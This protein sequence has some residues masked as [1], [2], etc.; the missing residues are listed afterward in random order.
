MHKSKV[1]CVMKA[2]GEM[3]YVLTI[4]DLGTRERSVVSFTL[5]PLYPEDT[6][7]GSH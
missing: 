4:L 2:Y 5:L 1:T 7:H 3:H 6:D